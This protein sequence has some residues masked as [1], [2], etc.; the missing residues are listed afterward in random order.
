VLLRYNPARRRPAGLEHDHV[1]GSLAALLDVFTELGNLEPVCVGSC[2]SR[3]ARSWGEHGD[4]CDQAHR[5]R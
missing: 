1:A 5:H 2:W 4:A 3:L